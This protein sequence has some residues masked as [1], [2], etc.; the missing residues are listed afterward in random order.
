MQELGVPARIARGLEEADAVMTLRNHYRRHPQAI[1]EAERRNIPVYV[2]R[3]NTGEQIRGSLVTIFNL[4]Y[5]PEE[6]QRDPLEETQAA[7]RRVLQGTP[8]VELSPQSSEIRRQQHLLA[9]EAS[10]VSYSLGS[11]PYR[12]V[13]IS[14]PR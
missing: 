13:R 1:A 3:S 2:L 12:R 4:P 14:R 6:I 9:R 10:L 8:S 11:E 5:Q 7:I